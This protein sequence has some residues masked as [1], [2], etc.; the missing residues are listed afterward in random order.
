MFLWLCRVLGLFSALAG[1]A[2]VKDFNFR[3]IS[4][5]EGLSQSSVFA[6]VQDDDGFMWFGT[7]DGLNQYDG[8]RFK[9]YKKRAFDATSLTHSHIR[10]LLKDKTGNLWIG[11]AY[12]LNLLD[13]KTKRFV[14]LS[15]LL[16]PKSDAE[17]YMVNCLYQDSAGVIWVGT[18]N[19]L[20]GIQLI[21]E[22]GKAPR[23]ET[24]YARSDEKEEN[25]LS[26]SHILSLLEDHQG[27]LWIG[28]RNG[29]NRLD[30][31]QRGKYKAHQKFYIRNQRNSPQAVFQLEGKYISAIVQDRSGKLWIGTGRGLYGVNP[32]TNES[33][34]HYTQPEDEPNLGLN[35]TSPYP[36]LSL[37]SS[38]VYSLLY[39]SQGTLWV[40]TLGGGIHKIVLSEKGHVSKIVKV[41]QNS[42]LKLDVRNDF[43]LSMYE[44]QE[45]KDGT[46]WFGLEAG[47]VAQFN[48]SKN[49]FELYRR[50]E[51]SSNTLSGNNIFSVL[52]DHEDHLWIGTSQGLNRYNPNTR[53]YT[54]YYHEPD[55][56]SSLSGNHVFALYEDKEGYLWVGTSRGLNRYNFRKKKFERVKMQVDGKVLTDV[57][58]ITS[59][60]EDSQGQLWI[61]ARYDL[62]RLD[63]HTLSGKSYGYQTENAKRL[64]GG[65]I[66]SIYEDRQQ[67]LWIGTYA[68]LNRYDRQRDDFIHYASDYKSTNSLSS[69]TIFSILQDRD[70]TYWIAT[71]L[72][73]NKMVWDGKNA[74]FFHYMEKDGLPNNF[75]YGLLP[76]DAGRI[77][78]S[79]NLGI[80]VMDPK[81]NTFTNYDESDGLQSKEFN[82]GAYHRAKNGELFFGGIHGLNGFFPDR[83]LVNQHVP[84][85]SIVALYKFEE[86]VNLDS[87]R[88]RSEVITFDY[89]DNF[90]SFEFVS[91]D[92]ANPQ[93]N[94]Y[95]YQLEGFNKDWI[96][97]GYRRYASF[98]NLDP[99]EYVFKV[100]GSND[101]GIWNDQSVASI[102]ISIRPPF[103]RTW[104]F[105]ALSLAV[106]LVSIKIIHEMRVRRKLKRLLELE[107]IRTSESE[108]IRRQ[109]ASDFHDEMGNRIT[110]IGVLTELIKVQLNGD[111]GGEVGNLL[112][113]I[114]ENCNTLYN[115]TRDFIW[116][117][118]PD[119][120]SFYEV[121]VRL[122]DFGDELFDNTA[123]NFQVGEI[124][125]DLRHVKLPMDWSRQLIL[126]F[127]EALN[128]SLKHADCKNV[129]LQFSV[130]EAEASISLKDDGR[131]FEWGQNKG[132]TGLNNMTNRA[133]KINSQLLVTTERNT[134]TT[135]VFTG[136]LPHIGGVL[137]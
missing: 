87:V 63:K 117:I 62:I 72:G 114:S 28:T 36:A 85:V 34:E 21:T 2:Q 78:M 1:T 13:R 127:K 45:T 44:S 39:D 38:Q 17:K 20:A 35:R 4:L 88:N 53:Q 81:T 5:S 37:S 59:F 128:N 121:A 18:A 76:D 9:V 73:L 82:A 12:G 108:K 98:T 100:K 68:G 116:S 80:S 111:Y 30:Q 74:S 77:W 105:Y 104:W 54:P 6:I 84:R 58:A 126:I 107:K 113:K 135:I 118:N 16:G 61:G 83:I 96:Y 52:K 22:A 103:W 51:L 125:E 8:Y 7:Q 65:R 41:T 25:S 133:R 75:I 130:Y 57:G 49:N 93:K 109:T 90:F 19:G 29:L 99:G 50:D 97:C 134:G 3:Q 95:A 32:E 10:A 94:R 24:F 120:N 91:L 115:G 48:P 136:T 66:T 112:S 14:N 26:S 55:D 102:R 132:G 15:R 47:G 137:V 60:C 27:H 86:P 23:Y 89:D 119:N 40:G 131:G 46:L 92:Y 31:E 64:T 11:T 101:S 123:V 124:S 70:G 129:H 56:S 71:D 79:T 122:K 43:V 67:N 69:N 110:R 106:V 33:P 42:M